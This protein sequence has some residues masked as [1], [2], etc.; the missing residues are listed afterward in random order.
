LLVR[1]AMTLLVALDGSPRASKVLAE[2]VTLARKLQAGLVLHRAVTV[3][4]ELPVEAWVT[5]P[6]LLE[7]LLVAGARKEVEALA[8]QIPAEIA[9][10]VE[11]RVGTPW[12]TIGEAARR[13]NADLIVIGSHGYHL[14]ER[15]L[16]T[17]A[18]RVVNHADRS[19]LVV[20]A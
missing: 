11:V 16:G 19:V 7:E 9:R 3:P 1:P 17:T 18:A 14:L 8:A 2:A 20:R 6:N 4:V 12:Q 13:V 5:T 15:I 10:Q